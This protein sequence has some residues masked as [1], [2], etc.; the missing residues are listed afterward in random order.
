MKE[1]VLGAGG[2]AQE[3][4]AGASYANLIQKNFLGG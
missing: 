1:S 4:R 2:L 3:L